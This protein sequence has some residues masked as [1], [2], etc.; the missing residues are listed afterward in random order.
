M[1]NVSGSSNGSCPEE[2]LSGATTQV[3]S[4]QR[5]VMPGHFE[6]LFEENEVKDEVPAISFEDSHKESK[7]KD[8]APVKDLLDE[9]LNSDEDLAKKDLGL[10]KLTVDQEVQVCDDNNV[11]APPNFDDLKKEIREEI[12]KEY[13]AQLKDELRSQ[14]IEIKTELRAEYEAKLK[15]DLSHE[16]KCQNDEASITNEDIRTEDIQTSEYVTPSPTDDHLRA[17]ILEL[18]TALESQAQVQQQEVQ[19]LEQARTDEKIKCEKKQVELDVIATD[20]GNRERIMDEQARIIYTRDLT[21]ETQNEGIRK[22]NEDIKKRNVT[23]RQFHAEMTAAN[24]ELRTYAASLDLRHSNE[25]KNISCGETTYE[26]FKSVESWKEQCSVTLAEN[27][28]LRKKL[29]TAE[30]Q[31]K[32]GKKYVAALHSEL[33][34]K[35]T[36]LKD[37]EGPLQSNDWAASYFQYV[38]TTTGELRRFEKAWSDR[39]R[40]VHDLMTL[41]HKFEN[42][43]NDNINEW[44]TIFEDREKFYQSEMEARDQ[45]IFLLSNEVANLKAGGGNIETTNQAENDNWSVAASEGDDQEGDSASCYDKLEDLNDYLDDDLEQEVERAE[46]EIKAENKVIPEEQNAEEEHDLAIIKAPVAIMTLSTPPLFSNARLAVAPAAAAPRAAVLSPAIDMNFNRS[47]AGPPSFTAGPGPSRPASKEAEEKEEANAPF[48][49]EQGASNTAGL[50]SSDD[51]SQTPSRKSGK[52]SR[53]ERR[54]A[55][56]AATVKTDD[57][58]QQGQNED[59]PKSKLNRKERRAKIQALKKESRVRR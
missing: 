55:A 5:K 43:F 48:Q 35:T 57:K 37:M 29:T 56:K 16:K 52:K 32:E 33:R 2:T 42:V 11:A 54:A 13:E 1:R 36:I 45:Q 14:Q 28:D 59:T 18:E 9:D 23:V 30:D 22:R 46:K 26:L 12:R 19:R 20:C 27:S 24:A 7:V 40:E 53:S 4:P 21:L 8:D 51:F 50:P 31:I 44:N 47:S 49:E 39:V 17:K 38:K 6:D 15:Y 41:K 25:C 10:P 58:E 34:E 3:N